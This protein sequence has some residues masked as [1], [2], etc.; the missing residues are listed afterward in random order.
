MLL[1]KNSY[2]IK[3]DVR[4]PQCEHW[5]IMATHGVVRKSRI[6]SCVIE[7]W[8]VTFFERRYSC[9]RL[10]WRLFPV[11]VFW[12]RLE[13]NATDLRRAS[14]L[15]WTEQ[16]RLPRS[17]LLQISTCSAQNPQLYRRHDSLEDVLLSTFMNHIIPR[18]DSG[19]ANYTNGSAVSRSS[20]TCLETDPDFFLYAPIA[21]FDLLT[22]KQSRVSVL[23]D[24]LKSNAAG[25]RGTKFA[26]ARGSGVS[27]FGQ[28]RS[29]ARM[30]QSV[31]SRASWSVFTITNTSTIAQQ[32]VPNFFVIYSTI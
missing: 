2:R 13:A 5:P 27:P 21:F 31:N 15:Q 30:H 32:E 26:Y 11:G 9:C 17:Q 24:S 18:N 19:I 6:V 23:S 10:A 28:L 3:I 14:C 16:Y 7:L 8:W 25:L 12:K 22:S 1:P 29:G 20:D 4:L